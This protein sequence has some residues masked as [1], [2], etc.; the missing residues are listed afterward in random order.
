MYAYFSSVEANLCNILLEQFSVLVNLS[1]C[2]DP[3]TANETVSQM[4]QTTAIM[5]VRQ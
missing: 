1:N 3:K 2:G 5:P 4:T